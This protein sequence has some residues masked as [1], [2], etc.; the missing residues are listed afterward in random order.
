MG[1]WRENQGSKLDWGCFLSILWFWCPSQGSLVHW[2]QIKTWGSSKSFIYFN[3]F[4]FWDNLKLIGKL[5]VQ[6]DFLSWTIWELVANTMFRL[7]W[8]GYFLQTR[9]FSYISMLMLS[10]AGFS[11]G[12]LIHYQPLL[13]RFHSSFR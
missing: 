8:I 13:L 11:T 3:F 12:A 6:R 7:P 5:L 4:L 2:A 1:P 10:K 9:T